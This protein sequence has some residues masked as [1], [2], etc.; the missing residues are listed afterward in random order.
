MGSKANKIVGGLRRVR[1][2]AS[3]NRAYFGLTQG[4][5]YAIADRPGAKGTME[6]TWNDYPPLLVRRGD[7]DLRTL[8][9][10]ICDQGYELPFGE[11]PT[12]PRWIIDAGAN[13]GMA[14]AYFAHAYPAATVIAIE[15]D[16]GNFAVLQHNASLFDNI[17]TI[18]AALWTH[19]GM[20]DLMDPG[21]GSWAFRVAEDDAADAGY[22]PT[23]AVAA[24]TVDAILAE[25][26]IEQID[27]LKI[28]IE[29]GERAIFL[30]SDS[31]MPKVQA[32]AVEL[33]D[34]F[35]PGCTEAFDAAAA[36][37]TQRAVRGEDTFALR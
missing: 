14:A 32:I 20:V 18:N 36:D 13:T 34:R 25:H 23:R 27:L 17:V 2:Q 12:S 16:P 5:R 8:C 35:L 11:L 31:W 24:V 10:V 28:D 37:F 7:T 26:C 6:V 29:G 9:H 21:Q 4:W 22:P 33:H 19:D 3:R 15:P 1:R 30:N